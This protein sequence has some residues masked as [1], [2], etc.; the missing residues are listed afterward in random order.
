MTIPFEVVGLTGYY[1]GVTVGAASDT[2]VKV[3]AI[4]VATSTEVS[5]MGPPNA[6]EETLKRAVVRKLEYVLERQCK[7]ASAPGLSA[8]STK[9]RHWPSFTT[10]ASRVVTASS[11]RSG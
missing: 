11:G 4:D 7:D 10:G 8:L 1:H 2:L 5:I 9:P 3:S 6:G